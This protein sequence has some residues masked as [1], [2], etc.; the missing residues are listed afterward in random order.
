[1]RVLIVDDEPLA[2]SALEQALRGRSDIETLDSAKDAIQA[3]EMMQESKYDVLLLDIG[4]PELS[5]IDLA[6]RLNK[7]NQPI[8]SIIFVTAHDQHAIAAFE[9]HAVD[10][11]LKPFSSARI[12]RALNVAFR[13]TEND[14][15]A[16]LLRTLP[17]LEISFAK[18]S[19][20][21]AIKAK[22]RILFIDPAEVAVI[23]AE[24]NYVLLEKRSGSYL[25]RETLSR[26]AEKLK[27]HGF[28]RIHRSM[29]V[30]TSF[31]EEIQPWPTGEYVLKIK[32][33][34]ELTVTRMYKNNLKSI[35]QLWVGT[36]PFS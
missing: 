26:V 25:L 23:R 20:K 30:N 16:R 18:P 32:G 17:L 1:M 34:Q 22:G 5:G 3:L 7:S 36:D 33:G 2:R 19:S 11:V 27:P 9:N 21:V 13:R 6:D 4:M 29:L 10:Y 31:V 35:A 28:I 14:R 15:A 8:P 12:N 24:G